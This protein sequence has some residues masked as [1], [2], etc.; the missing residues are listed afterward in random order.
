MGMN[1]AVYSGSFNPLHIG[2]QA[3]MEH[4]AREGR[5]DW[6][7]LVVSP[8]NPLKEGISADTGD[9]RYEAAIEAVKRHP[10]LRVRVDDIEL[11]MEPPHYTIKTLD[12]LKQREPENDFTLVIGAD[13]LQNIHRWRDFQRILSE[14]GVAVFPRKGFDLYKIKEQLIEECRHIPAPYVLDASQTAPE[15]VRNLEETLRGI[16]NIRII[17]APVVDISSTEIR[18]GL[19][20]GKDMSAWLM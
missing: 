6:V 8:K 12:A 9:E 10:E 16:Y 11:A 1:I 20:A 7:Y 3:I 18:K 4:L 14:Y 5:Y 17:D 19:A 15:G 13:N 2:H